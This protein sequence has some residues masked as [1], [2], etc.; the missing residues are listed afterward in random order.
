P[1]TWR[2]RCPRADRGR[3]GRCAP[4]RSSR[5][6][7]GAGPCGR[8][9]PTGIPRRRLNTPGEYA[10]GPELAQLS[11]AVAG[12]PNREA[13]AVGRGFEFSVRTAPCGL[14]DEAVVLQPLL[15]DRGDVLLVDT[16]L[17]ADVRQ[18]VHVLLGRDFVPVILDR[19]LV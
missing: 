16:D 10:A 9:G 13:P 1:G 17:L 4:A 2:P 18:R 14:L 5:R 12:W 3:R 7:H 11:M 6:A 8:C 15:G 19:F